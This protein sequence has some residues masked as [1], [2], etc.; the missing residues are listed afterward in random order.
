MDL[1]KLWIVDIETMKSAF[2]FAIVR[3]D[4]KHESVF[5]CSF[6]INQ[7]DRFIKC[8]KY[9][10]DNGHSM[11]GFNNINFDYP[12]IHQLYKSRR[13]Y[14]EISG[15]QIAQEVYN[16][17]QVQIDSFKDGAFGNTIKGEEQYV[18]QI[19][20]YRIW[21][22]NNKAKATG[23]KMLQFNMRLENIEDLPYGVTDELTSEQIDELK[24]YNIHDIRSTREFL[25][26]SESQIKFREDMSE[27]FK[28]D[29]M[30]AD[31]TKI[32]AEFFQLKLEESGIKLREMRDGKM[33]MK[34]TKRPVINIKDCLFKYYDFKSP[35]FTSILNWFAAQKITETKGV[36]SDI[37][38]HNLGEVAK[39]AVME[40]KRKKFKSKP[41]DYEMKQF[42]KEH[43]N[44]WIEEEELK[45]T[46]YIFD[47]YGNHI[48]EYPLD[49]DGSPDFSKKMKKKRAP[50]KSYWGCYRVAET[51]NVMYKGFRYDFGTGGI[52]GSLENKVVRETKKYAI[53]D[54]DVS[55]MYPNLSISN[56][57]Y[58][59]HLTE[60]FCE[61]YQNLY[62]SRKSYAKGTTENAMLKLAL[63]GT[64]GKSN[65]KYS[66]FYDPKFTMSITINGQLSLCL[67][68]EKLHE[69]EGLK[70]IQVNT[71]GIT[72]AVPRDSVEHYK[73]ICDAWQKQVKLELE[74]AEYSKM[75]IRDVNNYLCLYTNGKTKRKGA[76]Q[77]E[78][79]GYHQNQGGLVIPMAA[80]AYMLHG[81]S[82]EEFIKNH[83]EIFD[84]MLRVKVP[85]SSSLVL[86]YENGKEVPQQNI[87][88]YYPSKSGGKLI[89]IMPPLEVGQ[90]DRELGIDTQ[91][92]VK[93]CNNMKDFDGDLD[94]DYYIKEARKLIVGEQ[95]I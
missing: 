46:E 41:S 3:G 31:D 18:P 15:E 38:E 14:S 24:A 64:Y 40:I 30:N 32:G 16:L 83:K 11:V 74:F 33:L 49:E 27:K 7:F 47:E 86:R 55:S 44:G 79:L 39:Y 90:P 61:V 53:I 20:L 56:N 78:D 57:V 22:F 2:T 60:K 6:R 28:K 91:Y 1:S 12:I 94:F 67:L 59:E 9:L 71:D 63:N 37:E 13:K 25:L 4:G 66:V 69:I 75:F 84:F 36:F 34:Q 80:E 70:V 48:M 10:I 65:D 77:Y 92:T 29:F 5:E 72:V 42:Q 85:R 51:L 52:H 54:A 82:V 8:M 17:A 19:D 50:K 89:K 62:E 45:A 26:K 58:P 76:Y 43:P 88:R 95:N 35:E 81:T 73:E 87:C 68:A 21:H 23:L 93:T